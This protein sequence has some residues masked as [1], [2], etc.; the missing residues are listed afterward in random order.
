MTE[1]LTIL[2]VVIPLICAPITALFKSHNL[3]WLIT[4]LVSISC[5]V[6]SFVILYDVI[7]GKHVIYELGGWRP[8]WGIEY[9]IDSLN[10][11]LAL[12]VSGVASVTSIYAFQSVPK[13]IDKESHGL[14][15]A[16]FQL[17]LLGLLGIALTGDIFNLFV[18]LE[19]SSLS[20]YAL[21]SMGKSRKSLTAAFSYLI[22]G[23]IGATFFLIGVGFL[24]AA[25]GSL[26]IADIAERFDTFADMQLVMT[27]FIFIVLGLGLKAAI[28][29]LHS[30]LPN[31]Y[32]YAPSVV[33]IFLS[34]TATKVSIYALLRVL[35]DLYPVEY[36]QALL[37]PQIM[38]ILGCFAI[39][40]GSY[41][42]WQQIELKRM[43]AFSSVAQIGYIVIGISLLNETGLTASVMHLFNHALIK[44]TLF[45]GAGMVM[46]RAN[47][48]KL[49]ELRG[50]GASMP[51]TFAAIVL[52]GLSLIGV[53]G[54][55]GFVTKWYLLE[56]A[57]SEGKY[58]VVATILMG[59]VLALAYVW[60]IVEAMYFNNERKV[61]IRGVS[62]GDI[63]VAKAPISLAIALWI[64][65][66]GCLYFGLYTDLPFEASQSVAK[67][68]LTSTSA[69]M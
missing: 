18:F 36:W 50:F 61:V 15:Y 49:S 67:A 68:L 27:G 14:F 25:S 12:I 37:L 33:S 7:D 16:A 51:W 46:Y 38:L 31:A 40:Y 41:R 48:T 17:C 22:L 56:A 35:F 62:S 26:N 1:Q 28:F 20:S 2:L 64:G 13:E 53:P 30:W 21:I 6:L 4:L 32:S 65:A 54:T 58:I 43:L 3:S 47:T 63:S 11:F 39:I 66:G 59:S 34:A 10:A 19:I 60:K 57:I 45:M 5:F 55:V 52:A 44:S 29:P 9:K 69:K 23:T 42:A 24:F 8:P